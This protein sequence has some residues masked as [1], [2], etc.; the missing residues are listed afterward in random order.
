MGLRN[1]KQFIDSSC[2]FVTTS[3]KDHLHLL[4]PDLCK[5]IVAESI[6]FLQAKYNTHALGYV[7]MP[8]HI[9]LILFFEKENKLSDFMRDMK[10]YTSVQIRKELERSGEALLPKLNYRH[11]AQVFK[12]WDD[13]F[14]DVWIGSQHVLETK[15]GYIHSN[16]LQEHWNLAVH[17]EEYRFSSSCFYERDIQPDIKVTHYKEFF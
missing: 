16:P 8:N 12:V 7:I 13:G 9:H 17:P 3:C 1:R 15:L 5:K 2:F 11:R 4:K 10:K 6:N 14:D